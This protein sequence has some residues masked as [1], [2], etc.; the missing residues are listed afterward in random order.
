M[1]FFQVSVPTIPSVTRW[2]AAWKASAAC[3]VFAPAVPSSAEIAET[4]AAAD[5]AELSQEGALA[6]VIVKVRLGGDKDLTTRAD[7]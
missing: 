5:E 6:R 7:A 1:S 2:A 3:F 4:T